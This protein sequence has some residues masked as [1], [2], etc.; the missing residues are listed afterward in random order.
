VLLRECL[1]TALRNATEPP[2][3]DELRQVPPDH[4]LP[5]RKGPLVYQQLRALERLGICRRVPWDQA[6]RRIVDPKHVYWLSIHDDT[7]AAVI[8]DLD[9]LATE[10]GH[11]G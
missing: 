11:C 7:F 6:R 9:H 10:P 1:V 8:A 3:T 2:S 4:L 5:W